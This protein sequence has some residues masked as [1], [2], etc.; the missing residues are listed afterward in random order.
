MYYFE[1]FTNYWNNRLGFSPI[2][3]MIDVDDKFL[4]I[5]LIE[6]FYANKDQKNFWTLLQ[7]FKKS[8][9]K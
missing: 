1:S 8:K 6:Y 7:N 4:L 5:E 2:F 9:G 3:N